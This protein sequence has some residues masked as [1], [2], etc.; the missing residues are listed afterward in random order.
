MQ[1]MPSTARDLSV[2]PT[3]PAAN[4]DGG[5]RYLKALLARYDG[6]V[7]KALAAYNAG[8]GAVDRHG[9]TPPFRETQAYVAAILEQMAE[10]VAPRPK[11]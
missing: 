8:M 9:G 11:P 1:L 2:D 5:A 10:A 3:D 4:I 6:D 7:I